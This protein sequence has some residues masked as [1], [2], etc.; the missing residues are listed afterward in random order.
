MD[1]FKL[2]GQFEQLFEF[3]ISYIAHIYKGLKIM[4]SYYNPVLIGIKYLI[5]WSNSHV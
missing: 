1:Y 5:L 4:N 2:N 3:V